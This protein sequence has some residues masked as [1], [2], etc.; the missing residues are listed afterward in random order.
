MKTRNVTL[1]KTCEM[2]IEP[3]RQMGIEYHVVDPSGVMEAQY[4]D[5]HN[6]SRDAHR[7]ARRVSPTVKLLGMI[8]CGCFAEAVFDERWRHI[9][10][11]R[12]EACSRHD[13]S[14]PDVFLAEGTVPVGKPFWTKPSSAIPIQYEFTMRVDGIRRV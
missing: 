12:I 11:E 6:R 13:G 14:G 3:K 7:L 4:F 9:A 8:E 5:D 10:W 1:E 2:T